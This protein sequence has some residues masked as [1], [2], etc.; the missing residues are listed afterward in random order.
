MKK[1]PVAFHEVVIFQS[2]CTS[3]VWEMYLFK[4]IMPVHA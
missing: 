3:D 4:S 2:V 1:I